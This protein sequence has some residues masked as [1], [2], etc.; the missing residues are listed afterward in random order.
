MTKRIRQYLIGFLATTVLSPSFADTSVWKISKGNRHLYMGGTVHVL[1][2]SDYPLPPSFE[3]AYHLSHRIVL[4]TD[5]QK[6]QSPAFQQQMLVQLTYTDGRGLADVLSAETFQKLEA[7]CSEHGIP[8][9]SI[10]HFKPGMVSTV[11]LLIELQRLGLAGEG[12][13]AFYHAKAVG[14]QK[15]LGKLETAEAQLQFMATMGQGQEDQMIEYALGDI[16]NISK[17]MKGL[18]SAWRTGDMQNLQ[19]IAIQ[20][21]IEQF[22]E[23]FDALLNQRNNAWMPKIESMLKS[24]EVEFVLV[25][26]L[27]FAGEQGLLAQLKSLGYKIEPF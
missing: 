20:P 24:A 4:E 23:T 14:D 16:E 6:L 9:E 11:L 25:G 10:V 26:I 3:K 17:L 22:P 5:M 21:Y 2:Q 12:V 1:S 15:K 8:M 7:Y 13:D 18:K 27:H 19:E